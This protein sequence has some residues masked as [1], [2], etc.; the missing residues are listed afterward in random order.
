MKKSLLCAL[1]GVVAFGSAN[2]AQMK[3]FEDTIREVGVGRVTNLAY[4]DDGGQVIYFFTSGGLLLPVD[5]YY[6][7]GDQQGKF[8]YTQLMMSVVGGYKLVGFDSGGVCNKVDQLSL[9]R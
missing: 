7:M 5:N 2:A 4:G 9:I 6:N 1:L 8:M 3:C